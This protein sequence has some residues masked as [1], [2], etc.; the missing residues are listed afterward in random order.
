MPTLGKVGTF[1]CIVYYKVCNRIDQ[2]ENRPVEQVRI[3]SV[4]FFEKSG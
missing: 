1:D 4:A 2:K 3:D